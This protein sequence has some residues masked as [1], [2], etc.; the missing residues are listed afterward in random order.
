MSTKSKT[1]LPVVLL[2]GPTGVGKTELIFSIFREN[3]EI[4]NADSMQVYKGM[5]IGSAKPDPSIRALIPHHLIDIKTPDI[6]YNAGEFVA[7]ADKI[8]AEIISRKKIPVI[9]GGTAFYFRNYLYGLPDIPDGDIN[10]RKKLQNELLEKGIVRLYEELQ[11]YDPLRAEIIHQNDRYRI[12]RAL[13][14]IRSTGKPLTS[15]TVSTDIRSNISPFIIGLNRDRKE[16]YKRINS[17][18][19]KMF[20]HGLVGEVKRLIENGYKSTDPGMKGIGYGEFFLQSRIG[21]FTIPDVAD[22]IMRN[23][24]RY[25]KRQMTFFRKIPDVNWFHPEDKNIELAVKKFI[26][27]KM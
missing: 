20:K 15:Y 2:F 22:L 21:E 27:E 25:A 11:F 13:E 5:D 7:R 10:I 26:A 18:V 12:L 23:S 9:S 6:Q 16:L 1:K 24:R 3:F 14:V 8:T 4:I 17:R 19:V